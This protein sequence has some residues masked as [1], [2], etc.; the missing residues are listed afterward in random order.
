MFWSKYFKSSDKRN[1]REENALRYKMQSLYAY[2]N[3]LSNPLY[4][5]IK[6]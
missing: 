6:H 2:E 4:Q 1:C 5:N 3:T